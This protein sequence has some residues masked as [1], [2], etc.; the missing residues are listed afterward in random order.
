[1]KKFTVKIMYEVEAESKR[2]ALKVFREE[3][4]SY[5]N[6]RIKSIQVSEIVMTH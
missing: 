2:S 5:S 3:L 1:M 6:Y 4:P